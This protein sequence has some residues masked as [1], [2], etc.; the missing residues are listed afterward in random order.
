MIIKKKFYFIR[1]GRTDWNEKQLCQGQIDIPLNQSGKN[2]IEQICPLLEELSFTKIITSPLSRA[3][4]SAK[5][6]QHHTGHQLEIVEGI[7]ERGWGQMEGATSQEMY[8]IEENEEC[9]PKFVAGFNI[10]CRI[11]FQTRIILALNTILKE[12]NPLIV[13][14]GRVFLALSEILGIPRIRQIPNATIIECI[15]DDGS[16]EMIYHSRK[17][18]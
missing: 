2:E 15:P 5:I 14:H 9:N 12:G 3:F 1:H 11:Q 16:W 10:E 4:Q 18:P 17:D 8:A 7:Q 13:S 6:I